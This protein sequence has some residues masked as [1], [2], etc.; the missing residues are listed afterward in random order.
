NLPSG[1]SLVRQFLLGQRFFERELGR[2]CRE[3]W[4][5]DTFGFNGQLPQLMRGAG[6]ERFLTQKLSWNRFHPPPHHTFTW[7]GLHGSPLLVHFPPANTYNGIA[8]IEQ[9]RRG[10]RQYKDHDRGQ[11]S[12]YLYGF[13]DGGGGPT[14]LMIERLS[15]AGDLQGLPQTRLTLSDEFFDALE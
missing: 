11:H 5:P 1:E 6:I 14:P 10:A 13:G 4:C 12:I 8:S 2:R 3:F 9:L 7:Q 15:R